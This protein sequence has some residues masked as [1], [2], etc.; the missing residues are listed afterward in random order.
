[1]GALSALAPLMAFLAVPALALLAAACDRPGNR[2]AE[3]LWPKYCARCHGEDGRGVPKQLAR[4]PNADL[5]RSRAR[6]GAA[7]AFFERRIA[8]GYG[9]M[10]G[11][12]RRL[13]RPELERLVDLS[14]KLAEIP[15]EAP[16]RPPGDRPPPSPA[17]GS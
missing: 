15:D 3:V 16:P 6:G 7:R 9:P 13:S 5:T 12:S 4:Y 8:Q 1:M 10:P 17:G 2:S 11:F 14:L